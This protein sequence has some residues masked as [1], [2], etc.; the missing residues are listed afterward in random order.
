MEGNLRNLVEVPMASHLVDHVFGRVPS[1]FIGF[2]G[3][4]VGSAA[5]EHEHKS[6]EDPVLEDGPGI[7]Q[8]LPCLL[9]AE[10]VVDHA[11]EVAN[12]DD[13]APNEEHVE[14]GLWYIKTQHP[15][16]DGD[17]QD[18]KRTTVD[19]PRLPNVLHHHAQAV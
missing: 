15:Q 11:D 18:A 12:E 19:A 7:S 5:E 4:E 1:G 9:A 16:G 10:K 14:H 8:P 6:D 13:G 17:D 3:V 2:G